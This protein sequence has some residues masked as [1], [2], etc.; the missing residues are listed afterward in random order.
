METD[1]RD[2]QRS[3][4]H[5]SSYS[6]AANLNAI[7]SERLYWIRHVCY[8]NSMCTRPRRRRH[9]RQTGRAHW[10]KTKSVISPSPVKAPLHHCMSYVRLRPR[11]CRLSWLFCPP[12]LSAKWRLARVP[13]CARHWRPT[14]QTDK[15]CQTFGWCRVSVL[16]VSRQ[17]RPPPTTGRVA[18]AY[19]L[20]TA[21]AYE[22]PDSCNVWVCKIPISMRN[23]EVYPRQGL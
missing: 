6:H 18:L 19:K 11:R 8:T 15:F 12:K 14:L 22:R 1:R 3:T 21:F 10:Q 13:T 9:H 2:R 17:R 7:I 23:C 16:F 20:V 4:D 5:H